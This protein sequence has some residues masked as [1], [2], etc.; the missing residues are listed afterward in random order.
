[1]EDD[2]TLRESVTAAEERARIAEE[3]ARLLEVRLE[4]ER[5]ARKLGI[6]DEDA[7]FQL[8]DR[9]RIECDETGRPANV[10]RLME[11]LIAQ[12]PWLVRSEAGTSVTNPPRDGFRTLS[13]DAVRRM[14]PEEI[15]DN[16]EAIQAAL[17][18]R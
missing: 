8:L 14:S 18:A 13:L 1:M 6:V 15:N 2:T 4:A 7:A 3:R 5:C 17:R 11:E 9:D 16:W 10:D 12:R